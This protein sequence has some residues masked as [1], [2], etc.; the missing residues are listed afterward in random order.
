MKQKIIIG[1]WKNYLGHKESISLAN[2][3]LE[4][5]TEDKIRVMVSPNLF[6]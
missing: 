2:L 3:L 5:V 4:I 6:I 1:N